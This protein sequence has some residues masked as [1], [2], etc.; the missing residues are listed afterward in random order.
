MVSNRLS[1]TRTP[2]YNTGVDVQDLYAM[3]ELEGNASGYVYRNA[4]EP[5]R[6]HEELIRVK[7]EGSP[8]RMSVRVSRYG[9]VLTEFLLAEV[10]GEEFIVVLGVSPSSSTHTLGHSAVSSL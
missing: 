3:E 5:Y 4:W 8:R 1:S 7:G 6:I 9:P 2:P 10:D